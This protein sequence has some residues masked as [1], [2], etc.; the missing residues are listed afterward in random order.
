MIFLTTNKP[1]ELIDILLKLGEVPTDLQL[2]FNDMSTEIT[3]DYRTIV[4]FLLVVMKYSKSSNHQNFSQIGGKITKAYIENSGK[5][6]VLYWVHSEL[7]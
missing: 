4:N 7:G 2:F 6:P 3:T 5:F 1:E